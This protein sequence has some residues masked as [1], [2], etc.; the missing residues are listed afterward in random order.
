NA[1]CSARMIDDLNS[2]KYPPNIKPQ[3]PALNSNAE[4]GKFRYDR[5]FMMQFMRVCRERPKNLKNL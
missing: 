5:D 2:I 3:N 1:L 4:P